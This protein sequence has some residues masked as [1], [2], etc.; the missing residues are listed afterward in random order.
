MRAIHVPSAGGPEVLSVVEIDPPEAGPGEVLINV[1]A[2]GVNFIDTYHRSGLYAVDYPFTPG[3]ECAGVVSALGPDVTN[4]AV[5]DRVAIVGTLG[6]YAEVLAAPADRCVHVPDDVEL[7]IAAAAMLQAMTAH[8]LIT[9]T[10]PVRRGDQCLIHAG[11]GGTG[12]LAIQLAKQTGATVYTTVGTPAKAEIAAAAGAD[13]VIDYTEKDF[14]TEIRAISG[15]ERPL[16]VVFDGVGATVF[17]QSMSLLRTRGLMATFGN[18]SGAVPPVAPLDL[19]AAGSIYLT[20]PTLF[21]YI[22]TRDELVDRA[23]AVFEMISDKTLEIR[24]GERYTLDDAAQA[25]TDL[26]ARRTM[27]KLLIIPSL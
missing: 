18:A 15:S 13:H 1:S 3:V 14:A 5:G 17:E 19:M 2:A 22:Q 9:D 25:H 26:E 7:D 23:D 11:A 8:Y 16:D 12:N 24:V 20:R 27:G 10:Y 4:L 21:D 6:A